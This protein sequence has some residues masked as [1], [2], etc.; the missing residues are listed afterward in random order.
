MVKKKGK[1]PDILAYA[2]L[3]FVVLIVIIASDVFNDVNQITGIVAK[4]KMDSIEVIEEEHIVGSE[5]VAFVLNRGENEVV[6]P[7]SVH[8]IDK[9]TGKVYK[10]GL[11]YLVFASGDPAKDIKKPL[12]SR[13]NELPSPLK[14]NIKVL[15]SYKYLK[16]LNS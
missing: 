3:S 12:I 1:G 16:R 8:I 14:P 9:S 2:S 6:L 4:G 7:N 13:I 10:P 5:D 11:N 15:V